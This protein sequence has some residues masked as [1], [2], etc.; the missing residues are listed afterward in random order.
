MNANADSPSDDRR[1]RDGSGHRPLPV[2]SQPGYYPGYSTLAQQK[3]WD[4]ATRQK[5]LARV[6]QVPPIR[7]FTAE[8]ARVF[9]VVAGHILPQDD[10]APEKRIPIVPWVDERL[11]SGRIPG[12][13][14]E[15]MPADRDAHRMGLQAIGLIARAAYHGEFLQLAWGSQD[16]LLKSLHDGKPAPGAEAI[17]KRM[18][19]AKYWS[20]LVGDCAEVYYAHPWAWDEIGFGGPA[21]PRPYMRLERGDPEPWEVDEKRYEWQAPRDCVSDPSEPAG[22]AGVSHGQGGT[23]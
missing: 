5:V 12:Y 22:N 6:Q 16:A 1:P 21:Y 19:V 18:S 23:H 15:H 2:T 14:F 20:M 9:E 11:F 3:F 10:R 8:E 17:W 13:R 4:A 7:F